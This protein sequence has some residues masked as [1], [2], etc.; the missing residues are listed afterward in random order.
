M[1]KAFTIVFLFAF[2]LQSCGDNP[3]KFKKDRVI[4]EST[5]VNILYDIHLMDAI[6]NGSEFYRKF[7]NIDSVDIYS[8]I[9][10]KHG[11]SKEYFD[12]TVAIYS[13]Q[14][15]LY[16]EVYD[17][18]LMKLNLQ[19][20]D[21]K[22]QEEEL[23]ALKLEELNNQESEELN[24]QNSEKLNDQNS[25]ELKIQEVKDKDVKKLKF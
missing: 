20:D 22:K 7:E 23:N 9:F 2:L 8:N 24:D 17:K 13:R 1:K 16:L 15:Q 3:T 5:F 19:I 18:V 4:P 25:E 6:T 11:V 14:P 21:L 10:E 12:T